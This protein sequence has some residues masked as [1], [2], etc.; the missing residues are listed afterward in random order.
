MSRTILFDDDGNEL[1]EVWRGPADL[2]WRTAWYAEGRGRG[3]ARRRTGLLQ[4]EGEEVT[5]HQP[6]GV[7]GSWVT[8]E[9]HRLLYRHPSRKRF[10]L[11][12]GGC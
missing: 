10:P 1:D 2:R 11:R 7:R 12:R 5:G 6:L 4:L 8:R 9:L 3:V